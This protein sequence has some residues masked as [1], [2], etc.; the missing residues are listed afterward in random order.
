MYNIIAYINAYS[1]MAKQFTVTARTVASWGLSRAIDLS[2]ASCCPP[3]ITG[4]GCSLTAV[5]GVGQ[6]RWGW[7]RYNRNQVM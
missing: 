2:G 5:V 3:S 6:H 7:S 4:A 1:I